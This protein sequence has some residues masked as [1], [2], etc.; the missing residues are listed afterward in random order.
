MSIH[1]AESQPCRNRR[2]HRITST[3][4]RIHRRLRRQWMYRRRREL[5]EPR[6]GGKHRAQA[7]EQANHH[8]ECRR[9]HK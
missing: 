2:I 9:F 5:G 3:L 1:H 4:H 7:Q 8:E 6:L